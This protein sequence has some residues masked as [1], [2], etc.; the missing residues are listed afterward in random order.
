[1]DNES[2]LISEMNELVKS[3]TGSELNPVQNET[4]KALFKHIQKINNKSSKIQGIIS[5]PTGTGKTRLMSAFLLLLSN[6]SVLVRG[7]V[8]L[9]LAPRNVIL[10]Q[11]QNNE[12][13]KTLKKRFEVKTPQVDQHGSFIWGKLMTCISF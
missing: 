3:V 2:K 11:T 9:W 10:E 1:M 12:L 7:N 5:M 13:E 8:V 6:E 4:L